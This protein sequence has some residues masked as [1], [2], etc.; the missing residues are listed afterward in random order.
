M[1]EKA[2]FKAGGHFNFRC[3]N[4]DGSIAWE[5]RV[6]NGVTDAF[7]SH[8]LSSVVGGGTQVTTWYLG[9]INNAAFSA[10]SAADTMGSHAGWTELTSYDEA[11]RVAWVE[12]VTGAA[13]TNASEAVFTI[14]AT[15]AVKGAFLTS[16]NT[17]GGTTGVLGPTGTFADVQNLVDGQTLEI[18][19]TITAASG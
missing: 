14:S 10:L 3:R 17:K 12:T 8:L 15:V 5:E 2:T 6:K 11:T 7:L 1:Q 18:T 4:K 16:S 13:A 19:Y 9:L